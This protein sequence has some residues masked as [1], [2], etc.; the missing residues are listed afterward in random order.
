MLSQGC[1]PLNKPHSGLWTPISL[2]YRLPIQTE[3]FL[4]ALHEQNDVWWWFSK[5]MWLF[6]A[7]PLWRES[8]SDSQ[9]PNGMFH[10]WKGIPDLTREENL[11]TGQTFSITCVCGVCVMCV[12]VCVCVCV[13]NWKLQSISSE[14]RKVV[15]C[16]FSFSSL[17]SLT[18]PCFL[19][20]LV[21]W[22]CFC[23][24]AS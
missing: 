1:R 10:Q 15:W 2:K 19:G 20:E 12:C 8:D 9:V 13:M 14:G 11:G 23:W 24:K 6:H 16:G 4:G 18:S 22:D 17:D 3:C 21:N 5:H 7:N